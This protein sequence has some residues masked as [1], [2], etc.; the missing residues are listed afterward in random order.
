MKGNFPDDDIISLD[1]SFQEKTKK[2][3]LRLNDNAPANFFNY[4]SEIEIEEDEIK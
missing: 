3:P 2:T 4:E 1:E